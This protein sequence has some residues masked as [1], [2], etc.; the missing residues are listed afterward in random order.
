M[1]IG[2]T[3]KKLRRERD[4]TQELL[5]EFLGITANAVSQWECDRTTPDI[6]QL[7]LLA[8]VFRVSADVLLGI[9]VAAKDAKIDEIYKEIRELWCTGQRT[10]AEQLCREGLAQFPDAYCIMEELAYYLSYSNDQTRLEESISL[11]ERLRTGANGDNTKNFAVGNLIPLYMKIG[12]Q[13]AAKQLADSVPALLYTREQCRRMTLR[14]AEWAD[15]LRN[16]L[17]CHFSNNIADLRNL[18]RAGNETH[19]LFTDEEL[20]VLW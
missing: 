10:Q 7:P 18:L 20:L 19:P 12:N 17:A 8:N 16:Q 6:S 13:E 3:I 2:S 9:D 4:M 15:D 5:A 14:G 1:S 11:F